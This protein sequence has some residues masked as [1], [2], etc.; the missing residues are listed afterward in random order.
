MT[1]PPETS[2]P[3]EE[4]RDEPEMRRVAHAMQ[5][6]D[7]A[8]ALV[9]ID[10][11]LQQRPKDELLLALREECRFKADFDKTTTQVN[12]KM[13][14]HNWRRTAARSIMTVAALLIVLLGVSVT[15]AR[16]LPLM[17]ESQN[18]KD[19]NVLL[20]SAQVAFASEDWEAA[21][22]YF[23]ELLALDPAS[24]EATEGLAAVSLERELAEKYQ[25]ALQLLVKGESDAALTAFSTLQ[26]D[27]PNYRD[28]NSRILEARALSQLDLL[29]EQAEVQIHLGYNNLALA[30]FNEIQ[31]TSTDYKRQEVQ[32]ALFRLNMS[33]GRALVME[34]SAQVSVALSFFN[35]ALRQRPSDTEAI[36]DQRLAAAF[37]AGRDAFDSGDWSTAIKHLRTIFDDRPGYLGNSIPTMLYQAYI[38]YGDLLRADGDLYKAYDRYRMAAELPVADTVVARGRMVEIEPMLTPTPTPAPTATVGPTAPP[39]TPTPTATPQPLLSFQ[40]RIIFKSDNPDA[41]G[42]W[43]MDANGGD[44][45]YLGT[46]DQYDA[47]IDA[48]RE[49]ERLSP[50]GQYRVQVGSVDERAQILLAR[51]F[52][53]NFEPKTLTRLAAIAYDP[54]W[55][56]DGSMIAFVTQEHGSDDIWLVSPDGAQT[57]SLVRNEWEWE[58]APSWSRDSTRIAFMSNRE[59]TMAIWVMERNGRNPRNIS[60]V[61]WPEYEPVWIK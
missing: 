22:S 2:S 29:Y 26:Y 11:Q 31:R 19:R 34:S 7:W 25:S 60:N 18:I 24:T 44:R 41:T 46:F 32:D 40:G 17:A 12:P 55:A 39:P 48:Y 36:A 35:A 13:S 59:G 21:E 56:P 54:V 49:T 15:R 43:V 16:L 3:T 1:P 33:E 61:P 20:Q 4:L 57:E 23:K 53:P 9:L 14:A 27:A 42:Y 30:T 58:K 5:T 10:Q 52:D 47:A 8:G 28:V 38:N 37:L 50:D 6:G 51:T 45:T